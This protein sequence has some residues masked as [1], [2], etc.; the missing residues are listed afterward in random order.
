MNMERLLGGMAL[1]ALFLG[2]VHP[3]WVLVGA[4][5]LGFAIPFKG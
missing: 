5:V 4:A 1:A 2:N 3:L